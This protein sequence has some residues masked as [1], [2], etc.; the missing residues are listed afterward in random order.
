MNKSLVRF[1]VMNHPARFCALACVPVFVLLSSCG[2]GDQREIDEVNGARLLADARMSYSHHCYDMAR[3]TIMSLRRNYPLAL[4]SRKKA[5]LLLDSIEMSAAEDS[6]KELE[7]S[8]MAYAGSTIPL[9]S[10]FYANEHERLSVKAKFYRRK[11][12]EDLKK[13]R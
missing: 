13:H 1:R 8:S 10:A 2:G 5:I 11:L 9:D 6:L 7:R 4:D 12:Q 3:D